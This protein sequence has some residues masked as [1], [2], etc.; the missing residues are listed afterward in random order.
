MST[1]NYANDHYYQNIRIDH[2][3][4]LPE[5]D[6]TSYSVPTTIF[7]KEDINP[8][9]VN[10]EI[11]KR[12]ILIVYYADKKID[13]FYVIVPGLGMNQ[14]SRKIYENFLDWYRKNDSESYNSFIMFLSKSHRIVIPRKI[15]KRVEN[16]SDYNCICQ[17]DIDSG[18]VEQF[19]AEKI[20]SK[21]R[22]SARRSER[23]KLSKKY[24]NLKPLGNPLFSNEFFKNKRTNQ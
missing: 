3:D 4:Y 14:S 20:V 5:Y 8:N 12:C 7:K 9:F 10:E 2:F 16:F 18:K 15:I 23:K 13:I 24:M 21:K 19:N 11:F 6:Y 1:R 22:S 17:E